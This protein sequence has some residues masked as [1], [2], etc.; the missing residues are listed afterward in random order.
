M[1]DISRDRHFEFLKCEFEANGFLKDDPFSLGDSLLNELVETIFEAEFEGNS[2]TH[3]AL[4]FSHSI[5]DYLDYLPHL[6]FERDAR[7]V[8]QSF[9]DGVNVFKTVYKNK[10][11]V[12]VFEN[13]IIDELSLFTLRDDALYKK[14]EFS[15]QD[16]PVRDLF[17]V[18][19]F[20]DGSIT[21]LCRE[22]IAV[23]RAARV[24]FYRYQYD[25]KDHLRDKIERRWGM[26]PWEKQILDSILRVAVH[27]M[28]PIRGVGG[29]M[30]L[31]HPCED[32]IASGRLA[33]E[34]EL[35]NNR[36]SWDFP[37]EPN[38]TMRAHQRMLVNLM[39]NSDGA[40]IIDPNGCVKT[41]R[42]WLVPPVKSLAA[43][44]SQGGTRHLTAKVFSKHIK[45][46]VFVISSDGPISIYS[47]GERIVSTYD[48][49]S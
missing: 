27:V 41:V 37:W 48:F 40:T 33:H 13:S 23:H 20:D 3:G 9:C 38:I 11:G 35:L 46:L 39:K 21:I 24:K 12:L 43:E 1:Q 22:G 17:L 14:P 44:E 16:A 8:A 34:S 32:H 31:L 10:S 45:G 26:I 42:S 7:E 28:G 25:Y 2:P 47:D 29:T 30:V 15:H 5:K 19:K 6:Q 49:A 4:I 36:N 18:K